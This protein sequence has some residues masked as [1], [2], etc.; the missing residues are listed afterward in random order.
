MAM[1][2]QHP[3]NFLPLSPDSRQGSHFQRN[4]LL[5]NAVAEQAAEEMLP[6]A[7]HQIL[8]PL[9]KNTKVRLDTS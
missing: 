9:K 7:A 4:R 6:P 3:N 1:I 8:T 2:S 5:Q